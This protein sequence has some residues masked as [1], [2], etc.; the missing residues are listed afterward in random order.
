MNELIDRIFNFLLG[1]NIDPRIVVLII[2]VLPI[3]EARLAIPIALKCGL[4][5]MQAFFYGFV[6]SS[7]PAFV[8]IAAFIPL[9]KKIAGTKLMN[10]IGEALLK[11]IDAKAAKITGGKAKQM[12]GVGAFVGVPLP[13]T[14]V[15]TGC[16]VAS[17]IGLSYIR[18]LC[19][20][21]IGNLAAST[22]V[23][24]ISTVF[25]DYVNIIMAIFFVIA[26]STVIV[27]LVKS[28]WRKKAA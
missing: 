12:L 2:A 8:L 23:L 27:L 5:S 13:L 22:L 1:L 11:R 14:G 4:S 9:I 28:F 15:W 26:A 18:S 17:V 16:A 20:V 25:I 19:S 21:L 6:G 24:L 3:A 7:L 10:R